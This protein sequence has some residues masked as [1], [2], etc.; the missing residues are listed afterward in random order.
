[1]NSIELQVLLPSKLAMDVVLCAFH[2]AKKSP[3]IQT[4]M[5][6]AHKL[7]SIEFKYNMNCM[8]EVRSNSPTHTHT[9]IFRG[10][11]GMKDVSDS[12]ILIR[13]V[14]LSILMNDRLGAATAH[15][16][17]CGSLILLDISCRRWETSETSIQ[18]AILKTRR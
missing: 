2:A 8:K 12:S 11:C 3:E 15:P 13:L 16:H 17:H 7:K 14:V 1:M 9:F 6:R 10:T 18:L 5:I 4:M